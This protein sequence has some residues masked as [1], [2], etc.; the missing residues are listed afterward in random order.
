MPEIFPSLPAPEPSGE[1]RLFVRVMAAAADARTSLPGL[2]AA[3]GVLCARPSDP[4]GLVDE[5]TKERVQT[6]LRKGC[7]APA[8]SDAE[9][10]GSGEAW[11][12]L[13]RPTDETARAIKKADRRNRF[14]SGRRRILFLALLSAAVA[15]VVVIKG[16]PLPFSL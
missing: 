13:D 15:Y 16:C 11:I 10:G 3:A 6:F 1:E 12:S 8:G 4:I 7:E 5:E 2:R 9:P 14:T